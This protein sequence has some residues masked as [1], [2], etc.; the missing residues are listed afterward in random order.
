MVAIRRPPFLPPPID[1]V[2]FDFPGLIGKPVE[3]RFGSGPDGPVITI[4]GTLAAVHRDLTVDV[5]APWGL[6]KHLKRF[7]WETAYEAVTWQ[8]TNAPD[9]FDPSTFEPEWRDGKRLVPRPKRTY[10]GPWVPPE[11]RPPPRAA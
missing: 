7:W 5:L 10:R 4:P 2:V 3:I 1:A 8:W 6:M 9:P 11:D